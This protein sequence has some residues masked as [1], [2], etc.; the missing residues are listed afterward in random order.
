[1][2]FGLSGRIAS[3]LTLVCLLDEKSC[4][5]L[6]NIFKLNLWV[7]LQSDLEEGGHISISRLEIKSDK[8]KSISH[9]YKIDSFFN[10]LL[11]AIRRDLEYFPLLASY[12]IA[13]FSP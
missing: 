8:I 4:K 10:H 7:I 6:G 9:F 2:R 11:S 5:G 3:C 12:P 1:M 13:N